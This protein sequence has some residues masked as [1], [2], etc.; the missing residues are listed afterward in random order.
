MVSATNT[1]IVRL[2]ENTVLVHAVASCFGVDRDTGGQQVEGAQK[3]RKAITVVDPKILAPFNA[4]KIELRRLLRRYGTRVSRLFGAV[5]IPK[6][7]YKEFKAQL[8][9][10]EDRNKADL[11][12][13][14]I[15]LWEDAIN[16]WAEKNVGQ[17][18]EIRTLAP[19][20]K[21][22]ERKV[23]IRSC[24][25]DGLSPD[26]IT[27][28]DD[29]EMEIGIAEA[30]A[31]EIVSM[32]VDRM[33]DAAD[34]EKWVARTVFQYKATMSLLEDVS[35]KLRSFAFAHPSFEASAD[36]IDAERSKLVIDS[37][38]LDV[39]SAQQAKHLLNILLKPTRLL[40]G[41]TAF[42]PTPP[43][44]P[45]PVANSPQGVGVCV[46]SDNPDQPASHLPQES[47]VQVAVS[48]DALEAEL[49]W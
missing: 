34:Y 8:D 41:V 20:I 11:K 21:E 46:A 1:E 32:V 38:R 37:G 23:G 28:S 3:T 15:P 47:S 39:T 2:L 36:V 13:R 10:L 40:A 6:T 18:T 4:R 22:L 16:A 7:R 27:L 48:G 43:V 31:A 19:G 45:S 49:V 35:E 5:A 30:C 26:A 9:E 24:V 12:G 25:I 17:A 42:V 29:G 33:N 44:T 14:L